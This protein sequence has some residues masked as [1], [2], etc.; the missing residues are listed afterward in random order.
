MAGRKMERILEG[1]EAGKESFVGWGLE[2][3]REV[4][5]DCRRSRW[6]R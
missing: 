6:W 2:R 5:A 3:D 1:I 4:G